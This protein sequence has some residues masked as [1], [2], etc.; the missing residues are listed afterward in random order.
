MHFGSFDVSPEVVAIFFVEPMLML[1]ARWDLSPLLLS[2][3]ADA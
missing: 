1:D 3:F 2:G